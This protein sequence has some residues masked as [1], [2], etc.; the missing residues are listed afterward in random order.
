MRRFLEPLHTGLDTFR[1]VSPID[2]VG[3]V[4]ILEDLGAARPE[5]PAQTQGVRQMDLKRPGAHG[6]VLDWLDDAGLQEG[7]AQLQGQGGI[8]QL[9]LTRETKFHLI[10]RPLVFIQGGHDV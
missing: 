3:H 7:A 6:H 5:N 1:R 2:V 4:A 10:R 9:N 8:S